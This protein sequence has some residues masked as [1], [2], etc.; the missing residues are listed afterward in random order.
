VRQAEVERELLPCQ[1]VKRYRKS[2]R[3]GG[4]GDDGRVIVGRIIDGDVSTRSEEQHHRC[5]TASISRNNP[6]TA[7]LQMRTMAAGTFT[8]DHRRHAAGARAPRSNASRV[9]GGE[10]HVDDTPIAPIP[11]PAAGTQP[12]GGGVAC[13]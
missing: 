7:P 3:A 9:A 13:V 12:R 10:R 2:P 6:R 4:L 1:L 8:C 11:L 5:I